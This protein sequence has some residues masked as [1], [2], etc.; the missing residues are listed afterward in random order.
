MMRR[1][2]NEEV[3]ALGLPDYEGWR[4]R[5]AQ[6]REAACAQVQR[7]AKPDFNSEIWRD[8]KA[9]L[10]EMFLGKCAYCEVRITDGFWGDVEHYRPKRKV[11][12]YKHHP[13]YYWLAYDTRNLLPSCQLCNQG[14]GKLNHFPVEDDLPKT[15]PLDLQSERPL[16]L[17]PYDD[18][19][20]LTDF[21]FPF[22]SETEEPTG[23]VESET[24]R[25][26][27]SIRVYNLNRDELQNSRKD[28]Q[29]NAIYKYRQ[30]RQEGRHVEFLD[31]VPNDRAPF[32]AAR[33][34]AILAW[35][36]LEA[37]KTAE[38]RRR[39]TASVGK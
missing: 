15:A 37:E 7:G 28:A 1:K 10:L 21:T 9:G 34:A 13:G 38:A 32:T 16:L 36:D 33:L 6:A 3:F 4:R 39:L 20:F 24:L 8:V 14:K 23:F 11:E 30:K 19:P 2:Y 5:A 12:E 25:G 27:T 22:D 35:M 29:L 26:K 31:S 17:N 18:S